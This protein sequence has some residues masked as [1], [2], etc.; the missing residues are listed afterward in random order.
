MFCEKN[1]NGNGNG[2]N[3][4]IKAKGGDGSTFPSGITARWSFTAAQCYYTHLDCRNCVLI[5]YCKSADF[6]MRRVVA[7]LIRRHGLNKIKKHLSKEELKDIDDLKISDII[8]D[9]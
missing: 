7:E 6:I 4:H 8:E 1:N 5:P 9:T 2:R 3:G